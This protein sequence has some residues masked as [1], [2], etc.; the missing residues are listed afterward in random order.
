M[1]YS[2]K[3]LEHYN[4]STGVVLSVHSLSSYLLEVRTVS[5]NTG[6]VYYR[7]EDNQGIL[8]NTA[9]TLNGTKQEGTKTV[10]IPP[11][12]S[13]ITKDDSSNSNDDVFYLHIVDNITTTD[14]VIFNME[15]CSTDCSTAEIVYSRAP[16]GNTDTV[17]LLI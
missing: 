10:F 6:W 17:L 9:F 1:L 3:S 16:T 13:W 11:E 8:S 14:E 5:N 7:Y 12:N 4:V 2:S 15:L